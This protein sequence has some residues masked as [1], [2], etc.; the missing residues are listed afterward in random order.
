[1]SYQQ[2]KRYLQSPRRI[3]LGEVEP[4]QRLL[5]DCN[6]P[7]DPNWPSPI[8]SEEAEEL[9]R[10]LP[11]WARVVCAVTAAEMVLP[12]WE[13]WAEDREDLTSQLEYAPADAIYGAKRWLDKEI[14]NI[15]PAD[16][17]LYA[18]HA[19]IAADAA[20]YAAHAA[21]AAH[22]HIAAY[23]AHAAADAAAAAATAAARAAYAAADAAAAAA[24]A[25]VYAADA[26][27]DAVYA[28]D[29]AYDAAAYTNFYLDW[30]R[31]CRCRLSFILEART[32]S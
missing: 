32:L 23:A 13:D 24:R 20:L 25:A 18:A 9:M 15:A 14:V 28:A 22:A 11:R 30:W 3:V 8:H 4:V 16:A 7:E 31:V 5:R 1:M 17:A 21:H 29:A 6:I 26:A 12:I 10:R 2:I 19:H 27:Y